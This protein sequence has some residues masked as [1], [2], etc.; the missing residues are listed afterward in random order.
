MLTNQK[1]GKYFR[2]NHKNKHYF[3]TNQKWERKQVLLLAMSGC[4]VCVA[5]LLQFMKSALTHGTYACMY[6]LKLFVCI[7]I[8]ICVNTFQ[9]V[10]FS[11]VRWLH[12]K[13]ART[14]KDSSKYGQ[15]HRRLR[16]SRSRQIVGERWHVQCVYQYKYICT[17]GKILTHNSEPWDS[18]ESKLMVR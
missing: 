18:I 17:I 1:I 5:T 3:G 13:K 15:F 4:C 8:Y 11:R 10:C 6:D 2:T 16:P 14:Q 7:Y 9:V 12:S